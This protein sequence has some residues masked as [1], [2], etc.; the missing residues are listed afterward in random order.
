MQKTRWS[1]G[2]LDELRRTVDFDDTAANTDLV[3][4]FDD[5]DFGSG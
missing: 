3:V 5:T 1:V 2:A 4:D